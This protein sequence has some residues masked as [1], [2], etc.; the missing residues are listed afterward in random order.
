MTEKE[1]RRLNRTELLEMLLEQS[2]EIDNLKEQLSRME[3]IISRRRI[4][5][6]K[7]GS[8]AE[9]SLQLNGVFEAA[10]KAADQYVENI[11]SLSLR[12][13]S[14]CAKMEEESRRKSEQLLADTRE[15][16][17]A[18]EEETKKRC[19]HMTQEA[20]ENASHTWE[21]TR[22]R[23]DQFVEQRDDLKRLIKMLSEGE[24][25]L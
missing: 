10:Q 9:A 14:I 12:Q 7:A 11:Q 1:L 4:L 16:C 22:R 17:R 3:E 2:R 13:E 5:L 25:G 15:K 20:E 21:E 18:M 23:M 24:N 6:E 19:L 8:I